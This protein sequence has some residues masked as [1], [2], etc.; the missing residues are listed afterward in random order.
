MIGIQFAAYV[1]VAT[2]IH[3]LML[4]YLFIILFTI[5]FL[6]VLCW[7]ILLSLTTMIMI[8][9]SLLQELWV[10]EVRRREHFI[11][12]ASFMFLGVYFIDVPGCSWVF[13]YFIDVPGC[14]W[15]FALPECSKF[16]DDVDYR[17][18]VIYIIY[19]FWTSFVKICV[20]EILIIYCFFE[21]L[22]LNC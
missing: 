13:V 14:S 15:V 5:L 6:V 4:V 16:L 2:V 21:V 17:M 9:S 12:V 10:E 20:V 7:K 19:S 18:I 8:I 1:S 11:F 22:I 3:A